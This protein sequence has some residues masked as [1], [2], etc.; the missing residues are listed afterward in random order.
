MIEAG[1]GAG[2]RDDVSSR[3]RQAPLRRANWLSE[4]WKWIR[5]FT[6]CCSHKRGITIMQSKLVIPLAGL[7]RV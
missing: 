7:H 2:G 4:Q 1:W 6:E 3:M 5:A